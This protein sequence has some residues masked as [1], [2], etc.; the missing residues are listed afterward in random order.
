[1]GFENTDSIKYDDPKSERTWLIYTKLT[2]HF[3]IEEKTPCFLYR[4]RNGD[5]IQMPDKCGRTDFASTPPPLWSI[6]F[7]APWR[8]L[9]SATIHDQGYLHHW[10]CINGVHTIVTRRFMDV[11][12]DEMIECEPDAGNRFE[13][14]SYYAGVRLGGVFAWGKG[15]IP[16]APSNRMFTGQLPN[17]LK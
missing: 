6:P 14:A 2:F 12:L 11:L 10:L 7:F 17:I 9:Y 15:D 4:R 13:A 16:E 3:H 1:M 8:F 5:V